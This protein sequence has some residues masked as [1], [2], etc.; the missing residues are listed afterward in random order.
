MTENYII[1][2]EQPWIIGDLGLLIYEH[3]IKGKA[4]GATMHWDDTK[5][6]YICYSIHQLTVGSLYLSQYEKKK[7]C[8]LMFLQLYKITTVFTQDDFEGK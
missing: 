6:V 2:T 4:I 3:I 1:F 8:K 7:Y 5:V